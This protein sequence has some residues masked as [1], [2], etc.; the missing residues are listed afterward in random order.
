M[1]LKLKNTVNIEVH[2][3]NPC[4]IIIVELV[5]NNYN[6]SSS[7]VDRRSFI[8]V[9]HVFI[10]CWCSGTSRARDIFNVFTYIL[11]TYIKLSPF[12]WQYWIKSNKFGEIFCLKNK[13]LMLAKN[14]NRK[15]KEN[16]RFSMILLR[17]PGSFSIRLN[18]LFS[19]FFNNFGAVFILSFRHWGFAII[20][21]LSEFLSIDASYSTGK[22]FFK[23]K[24]A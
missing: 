14:N 21:L 8:I 20:L 23:I 13:F 10:G 19:S 11:K 22:W 24:I 12:L 7:C 6:M 15:S 17:S 16:L 9:F 18:L 5:R 4:F 1:P 2:L 3:W